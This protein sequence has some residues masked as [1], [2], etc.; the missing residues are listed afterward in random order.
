ME[1]FE[2]V[3]RDFGYGSNEDDSIKQIGP[4]AMKTPESDFFD[5]E[6]NMINLTKSA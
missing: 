4:L 3:K 6:E 1:S 2:R 5:P